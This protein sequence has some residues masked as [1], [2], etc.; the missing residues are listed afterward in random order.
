MKFNQSARKSPS[1]FFQITKNVKFKK[2]H[3]AVLGPSSPDSVA[4][5]G[6]TFVRTFS[7]V[8]MFFFKKVEF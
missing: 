7:K 3:T 1:V 2:Y 6:S 5:L 4:S 8:C